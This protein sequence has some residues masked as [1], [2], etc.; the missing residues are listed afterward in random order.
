MRYVS[1]IELSH[2]YL[3]PFSGSSKF[4]GVLVMLL[5]LI[6]N[7]EISAQTPC[8]AEDLGYQCISKL[9]PD[10][11]FLRKYKVEGGGSDKIEYSYVFTQGTQ[12]MLT[13]CEG[14]QNSQNINVNIFDS[15]RNL[16]ASSKNSSQSVSAIAYSCNAAGIYYIQYTFEKPDAKCGGS[17]LGFKRL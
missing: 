4:T 1:K 15:K 8:D 13:I 17:V 6:F 16:I 3:N 11:N 5:M 2:H 12:Y 9:A 10:F 7:N 14:T